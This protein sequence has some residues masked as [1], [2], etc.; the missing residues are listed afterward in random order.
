MR[1]LKIFIFGCQFSEFLELC[2][3]TRKSVNIIKQEIY[4]GRDQTPLRLV[5]NRHYGNVR[6]PPPFLIQENTYSYLL[7][8]LNFITFQFCKITSFA[9]QKVMLKVT[10]TVWKNSRLKR[11]MRQLCPINRKYW[12]FFPNSENIGVLLLP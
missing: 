5:Y 1:I 2:R 8:I 3:V 7:V 12:D 6:P 9:E 11:N 10:A 4:T